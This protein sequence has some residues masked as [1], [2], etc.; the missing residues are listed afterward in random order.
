MF[1]VM[2]CYNILNT[3]STNGERVLQEMCKV[4]TLPSC[5]ASFIERVC[6]DG[7]TRNS[8]RNE[9]N[10][11]V[12]DS[13]KKFC[14]IVIKS[15]TSGRL[16]PSSSNPAFLHAEALLSTCLRLIRRFMPVRAEQAVVDPARGSL[17][18]IEVK[19]PRYYQ[20]H[21]IYA[22][23]IYLLCC[24][25]ALELLWA[26]G[27]LLGSS[28]VPFPQ[29][30]CR[31]WFNDLLLYIGTARERNTMH[32]LLSCLYITISRLSTPPLAGDS[33]A[34]D[35]AAAQPQQN[36]EKQQT[37]R[38]LSKLLTQVRLTSSDYVKIVIQLSGTV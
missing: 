15:C 24:S 19:M 18:P 36:G 27:C 20:T 31:V 13:I 28:A 10:M 6:D 34:P 1:V 32:A 8:V 22:V 11:F 26:L 29:H 37:I 17:P 12:E 23:L 38:T 16:Q 5:I 4:A 21:R 9:A 33:V 25:T 7:E 2:L 35:A 3:L 30:E 14:S